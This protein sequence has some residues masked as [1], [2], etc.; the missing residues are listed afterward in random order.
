MGP[1]FLIEVGLMPDLEVRFLIKKKNP[2]RDEYDQATYQSVQNS[3]ADS[4]DQF[5]YNTMH[6]EQL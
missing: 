2:N 5:E 1:E 4:L 6:G 3:F